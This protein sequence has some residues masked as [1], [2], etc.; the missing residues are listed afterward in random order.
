MQPDATFHS[1]S[2]YPLTVYQDTSFLLAI[3]GDH[4]LL[5]T[6]EAE[7]ETIEMIFDLTNKSSKKIT[8]SMRCCLTQLDLPLEGW[9]NIQQQYN[10]LLHA[11]I[12]ANITWVPFS[13]P[14][15][16]LCIEKNPNRF[17]KYDQRT[18]ASLVNRFNTKT[19]IAYC[20]WI[21]DTI[22]EC[23]DKFQFDDLEEYRL[24]ARLEDF[25]HEIDSI[26]LKNTQKNIDAALLQEENLSPKEDADKIFELEKAVV[27]ERGKMQARL[28]VLWKL[29]KEILQEIDKI[30]EKHHE[31]HLLKISCYLLHT[32]IGHHVS[33]E[34]KIKW[35]QFVL[36]LQLLDQQLS[37]IS[38]VRNEAADS[39]SSIIFAIRLALAELS[40][41]VSIDELVDLSENW[42]ES[43][44]KNPL[45]ERLRQLVIANGK[46]LFTM[47]KNE[48]D[49]DWGYNLD[50]LTF[51]PY[52]TIVT[53]DQKKE[54]VIILE[55]NSHSN[56]PKCTSQG[57]T[58]LKSIGF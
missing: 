42:S 45:A 54:N 19:W 25:L 27:A 15:E 37:V 43:N 50:M 11:S 39:R 44:R 41:N 2:G 23:L 49:D 24:Q 35:P 7:K 53:R 46:D 14:T 57:L 55:S 18:A 58:F 10:L 8:P 29:L 16:R 36:F 30:E 4:I 9:S 40:Q 38:A 52:S 12:D 3:S 17:T 26:L 28:I 51:L 6:D 32:L 21:A 34:N 1:V 48:S 56:A 31:L 47:N 22:K 33:E 5:K 20:H 13:L